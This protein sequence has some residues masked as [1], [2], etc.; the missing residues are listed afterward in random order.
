MPRANSQTENESTEL[1]ER[2][3]PIK[4]QMLIEHFVPL[5]LNR[6]ILNDFTIILIIATAECRLSKI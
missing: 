3:M 1:N 5:Q 6:S 4:R 2:L